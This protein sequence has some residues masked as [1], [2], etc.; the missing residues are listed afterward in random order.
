MSRSTPILCLFAAAT[1]QNNYSFGST[2]LGVWVPDADSLPSFAMNLSHL[3]AS[4]PSM[5]SD[6]HLV[7]NDRVFAF[8]AADGGSSLRQDEGGP[9]LLNDFDPARF[10]FAGGVGWLFADGAVKCDTNVTPSAAGLQQ[11][12][13]LGVGR[14][15]KTC[16]AGGL[17]VEHTLW[18]PFGDAPAL[19][20][21]VTVFNDGPAP[22]AGV[23][24]LEQWAAGAPVLLAGGLVRPAAWEASFEALP[25]GIGVLTRRR[26]PA[27]NTSAPVLADDPA[28]RAHFL[29]SLDAAAD[30]AAGAPSFGVDGGALF[31]AGG[32]RRP[33]LA[34][35]GN[36][37]A[38]CVGGWR[39][40][41]LALATPP[42]DLAPGQSLTRSSL[43]GYLPRDADTAAGVAA[44]VLR[45]FGPPGLGALRASTAAWRDSLSLVLDVPS[46]GAWVARET[47]WHSYTLRALL[48]FDSY[49][50]RFNL[51]QNG[52]YQQA[53]LRPSGRAPEIGGFNGASRD[54][55]AHVI[56]FAYGPP[57]GAAAFKD[58]L[59]FWLQTQLD[60]GMLAWGQAGYGVDWR[61]WAAPS[62]ASGPWA[63]HVCSDLPYW[64]LLSAAEYVLATRDAAFFDEPV[65]RN[66]SGGGALPPQPVLALLLRGLHALLDG[67]SG[68]GVGRG[69][70]GLLRILGCDHN[71]GFAGAIN[72]SYFS[73]QYNAVNAS[74]ESAMSS[75]T[76][77]FALCRFA[78]A[79]DFAGRAREA[80]E[81]RAACFQ[82]RAAVAAVAAGAAFVPRAWL[83]AGPGLGWFGVDAPGADAGGGER[84]MWM[85]PQAWAV[86]GGALNGSAADAVLAR[87]QAR[88]CDTSPI[89]CQNVDGCYG[90]RCTYAGVDHFSNWPLIW[91]LGAT[92]RADAALRAL[93]KNSMALRA[94][95]YPMYTYG[96]TS[97]TDGWAGA[98]YSGG[99]PPG[100]SSYPT[101]LAFNAW[102]HSEPLH[103]A[104]NALGV[105][106][107]RSGVLL[108]GG[109]LSVPDYSLAAALVGFRRVGA[110]LAFAGWYQPHVAGNW[111]VG[112]LLE[113]A[114]AAGFTR[115]QVN[116]A[117][118]A[119]QR[120]P[121]EG[122]GVRLTFWGVGGGEARLSWA[123]GPCA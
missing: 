107:T 103:S 99:Q 40:A 59:K 25:G 49:R 31:G 6:I 16:A 7:G 50:G 54:S 92:G 18:A 97:G 78:D 91:A 111:S 46:L 87:V 9:K 75:A 14:L 3:A 122:G 58:T 94:H 51:N 4:A 47:Q 88:L 106:F 41:V 45:A 83:G 20:S 100:S 86:L 104:L 13:T 80:G 120:E 74:G 66:A 101:Y 89:G 35:L 28:P 23:Q 33:S 121:G 112:V 73:P 85:E 95:V 81:S 115:V 24:W 57:A 48:S 65:A 113:P 90:R 79:L 53:Y 71:D 96:V 102:E 56:P 2:P 61:G 30:A 43:Y 60:S 37:T 17:R 68:E 84:V 22:R 63:G 10:Q 15:T 98:L 39:S 82:L 19:I 64:P 26:N 5:Y 110:P 29:L 55:V 109:L 93:V 34:A 32:A 118:Q 21:T 77:A 11:S 12:M 70:H 27:G 123:L 105:V 8:V 52:E 72:A 69:A 114:V 42:S 108:Q 44:G 38:C 117:C 116:G 62:P 119:L 67:E 76:A 36:S 1:A